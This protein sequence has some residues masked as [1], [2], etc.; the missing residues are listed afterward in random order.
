MTAEQLMLPGWTN[1]ILAAVGMGVLSGMLISL[2]VL[3]CR[4]LSW[5][6]DPNAILAVQLI[7]TVVVSV[8]TV[9]TCRAGGKSPSGVRARAGSMN[10]VYLLT[11]A[12]ILFILVHRCVS[13]FAV[14]DWRVWLLVMLPSAVV[15]VMM[16]L[17]NRS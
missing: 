14:V 15:F 2:S 13:R 1:G 12:A 9:Y 5:I 4:N 10:L 11:A 16:K 6:F 17:Y 7:S 3:L 8:V